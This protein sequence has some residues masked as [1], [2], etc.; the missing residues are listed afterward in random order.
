MKGPLATVLGVY[1]P[2]YLEINIILNGLWSL[3]RLN[4]VKYLFLYISREIAFMKKINLKILLISII[5]LGIL[6][7][8]SFVAVG[9]EEEGTSG[10]SL[11]VLTLSKLFYV[12][13]FP[14]HTLLWNV[15]GDNEY[16]FFVLLGVN[17]LIYGYLIE[18]LFYKCT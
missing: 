14:T 4:S 2:E 13:R 15:M 10:G 16:V 6:T 11:A 7:A 3:T 12:L 8:V 9:A 18:R 1:T 5:F 17:V